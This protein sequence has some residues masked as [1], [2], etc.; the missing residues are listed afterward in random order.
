[1]V[2][3]AP[4][5]APAES[6]WGSPEQTLEDVIED[7][8]AAQY[9]AL[10]RIEDGEVSGEDWT[11]AHDQ[12]RGCIEGA[13][14]NLVADEPF[15]NPVNGYFA[16]FTFRWNGAQPAP[17]MRNGPAREV[18]ADCDKR[19]GSEYLEAVQRA[20]YSA[21]TDQ[22]LIDFVVRCLDRNGVEV[23][24]SA[25][26]LPEITTEMGSRR[27]GRIGIVD[28]CTWLGLKELFPGIEL[29]YLEYGRP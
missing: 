3:L 28:T 19:F 12:W 1:V 8:R 17:D 13:G 5:G 9:W 25:T 24:G 2:F 16:G 22:E 7:A 29:P 27:G 6:D 10:D 20:G 15:V 18:I 21:V 11:W 23:S 4:S 14:V 26:N